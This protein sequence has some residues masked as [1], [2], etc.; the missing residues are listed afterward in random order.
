MFSVVIT[1]KGGA[2]RRVDFDKNEV[3]IGRVQGN[4]IILPKGN[5]SKRHS[6]IVLKDNRFIVVDLKST[7]GT[8]VNGRKITSPLVVK[9][10][11][12]IYIGDFILTL[13][14]PTGAGAGASAPE[15]GGAPQMMG[16]PPPMAPP[17]GGPAPM[18]PP[19]GG[20]PPM[21]TQPA[22]AQ[23]PMAGPSAPPPLPMGGP[24]AM[25]ASAAAPQPAPG[26]PSPL[27]SAPP[28]PRQPTLG[29][30]GMAAA[31][32]PPPLPRAEGPRV[33]SEPPPAHPGDRYALE[34]DP[35]DETMAP[36]PRVV[37][38]APRAPS[39]P[40]FAPAVR[41]PEP[42]AAPSSTDVPAARA[43]APAA[44]SAPAPVAPAAAPAPVA[45]A[46]APAMRGAAPAAP[47]AAPAAPV[48]MVAAPVTAPLSAEIAR[49]AALARPP[50]RGTPRARDPRDP[51]GYVL[52]T[53]AD[54]IDIDSPVP[55]EA[56]E[57]DRWR[58]VRAAIDQAIARLEREG[59]NPGDRE[60]L[61][62]AAL[63]EALG[64]GPLHALLDD[65]GV[66][67]VVI[68]GPGS[69]LVDRGSGLGPAPGRFSTADQLAV[70]VGRLLARGG[71]ALDSGN[72]LAE[73]TL[74]DGTHVV[75]I[76]P[77]VALRGPVVEIRRT[78]RAPVTGETLV[79]QG[80]LSSDMLQTLRAAV[81]AR[82]NI[83][84]VGAGELGI[85]TVVSMIANLAHS[86]DRILAIEASPE[87][88]LSAPHVVRLSASSSVGIAQLLAQAPRLR[89]DRLVI[90]GVSGPET[91][92]ALLL[93]ASRGAGCVLG[94]RSAPTGGTLEHLEALAGLGGAADTLSRLLASAIHVLVT[95]A[96]D[97]HGVRR[98]VS[99]AEITSDEGVPTAHAVF[100]H[101]G[102][103]QPTGHRPS[104]VR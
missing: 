17:M 9:S 44:A 30:G 23:S 1:E 5:V 27:R 69:I 57:Q 94:V 104:F 74:P 12:K 65:P 56:L 48:P 103:F 102:E 76:M 100:E 6:R 88:A 15:A 86:D 78:G 83:V 67:E 72:A 42:A 21:A 41:M 98:I 55:P 49:P 79:Q 61:A 52:A 31:P 92:D 89:C 70:I 8:Y 16:G 14:E 34:E 93:L 85:S 75:A 58:E 60:S 73:A 68:E 38:G 7:N 28:P 46:A 50:R 80:L 84:V 82:R 29:P 32:A 97:V 77:P 54:T 33:P 53:L 25:G 11:D 4:D 96:R 95:V 39:R 26:R 13:E 18:A 63:H 59:G 62:N 43:A 64:F 37:S 2:Q 90:D 71:V 66:L 40:D 22:M 91:R 24:P 45:P 87:L 99:I 47:A 51:L 3:T 10:G 36:S 35:A 20:P 101:D 19:M 81:E